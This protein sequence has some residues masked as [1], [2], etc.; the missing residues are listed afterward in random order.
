MRVSP[1]K[2]PPC[3][4]S[5]VRAAAG[6]GSRVAVSRPERSDRETGSARQTPRRSYGC[7]LPITLS[8]RHETPRLQTV[9]RRRHLI[10]YRIGPGAS[11]T[12]LLDTSLGIHREFRSIWLGRVQNFEETDQ[13]L[14]ALGTPDVGHWE[15]G[16]KDLA[17]DPATARDSTK[18]V[19]LHLSGQGEPEFTVL[20]KD[21]AES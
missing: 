21:V 19:F 1:L 15:R 3:D 4:G 17:L 16:I 6:P 5:A 20:C 8:T 12:L 13:F 9:L 14:T 7:I 18:L 2:H 11:V 10:G